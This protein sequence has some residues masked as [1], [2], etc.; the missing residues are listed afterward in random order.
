MVAIGV[1]YMLWFAVTK[2]RG[3]SSCVAA[4]GFEG[5]R[6]R[7]VGANKIETIQ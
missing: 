5:D 7:V 4:D 3:S 2:T 1:A 6:F